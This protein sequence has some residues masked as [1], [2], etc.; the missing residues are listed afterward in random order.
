[1]DPLNL[2][3]ID[4]RNNRNDL[5]LVSCFK[6]LHLTVLFASAITTRGIFI[7]P[8]PHNAVDRFLG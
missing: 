8:F 1:M 4:P 3:D 7:L 2:R 5:N 6:T